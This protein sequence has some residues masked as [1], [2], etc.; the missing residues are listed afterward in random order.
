VNVFQQVA[1]LHPTREQPFIFMGEGLCLKKKLPNF[2]RKCIL[3]C[4][5]QKLNNQKLPA[6]NHSQN[7]IT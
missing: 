4:M 2:D 7:S 6:E 5:M 3:T 1:F